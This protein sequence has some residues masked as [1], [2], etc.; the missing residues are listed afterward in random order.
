M[1]AGQQIGLRDHGRRKE[2]W[3]AHVE[4]LLFCSFTAIYSI[5]ISSG[6]EAEICP[7]G[8]RRLL[9]AVI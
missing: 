2:R 6:L 9:K 8:N 4:I 3:A 1:F 7:G 5:L